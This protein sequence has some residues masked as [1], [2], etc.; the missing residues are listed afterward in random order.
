MT[1][2]SAKE[3]IQAQRK[4]SYSKCLICVGRKLQ[5]R[6]K[7]L[8]IGSQLTFRQNED[9]QMIFFLGKKNLRG[10][11]LGRQMSHEQNNKLLSL[12]GVETHCC[13]QLVQGLAPACSCLVLV[14]KYP[15]SHR[16]HHHRHTRLPVRL[17][18]CPAGS[19]WSPEDSCPCCPG[20]RHHHYKGKGH[21][22]I[23]LWIEK[24]PSSAGVTVLLPVL[25]CVTGVS[26]QVIIYVR[27]IERRM[28]LLHSLLKVSV[29]N[30]NVIVMK[31]RV[32]LLQY[33]KTLDWFILRK[34]K[35]W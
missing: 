12:C 21:K 10:S 20:D 24:D 19:C 29:L 35:S 17:C 6:K 34:Y 31:T 15:E 26:N 33:M 18:H 27:L 5:P 32:S 8:K 13:H 22:D 9:I 16:C 11:F 25:V 23:G 7:N 14:V 4:C 2:K 3:Q 28:K 1:F 30:L